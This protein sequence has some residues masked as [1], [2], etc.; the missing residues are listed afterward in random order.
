MTGETTNGQGAG[1]G[2][3]P[4][5]PD[6]SEVVEHLKAATQEIAAAGKAFFDMVEQAVG[7]L[8]NTM[9]GRSEPQ[10]KGDKPRVERIDVEDDRKPKQE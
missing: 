10:G 8:F 3:G 1:Y 2:T 9:T 5:P 4:K 6:A 7:D